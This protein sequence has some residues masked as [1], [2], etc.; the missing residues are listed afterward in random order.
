MTARSMPTRSVPSANMSPSPPKG[1][2]H[3]RQVT[4][5]PIGDSSQ[6]S[7]LSFWPVAPCD[8]GRAAGREGAIM[9]QRTSWAHRLA[10]LPIPVLALAIVTLWVADVQVVWPMRPLNFV[11]HY[12]AA[13]VG[14]VFIVIPAA[15]SFAGHRT[16]ER[17][18]ARLRRADDAD[19]GRHHAL[20]RKLWTWASPST[21]R[22][23]CC[24]PC[25]ISP[26]WPSPPAARSA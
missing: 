15:R 4:D 8:D 19:R 16:T 9:K 20:D 13:I 17:P 23:P 6:K 10:I 5:A 11:I 14:L 22:R 7:L 18:D 12:A 21:T 24:R 3:S 25:A 2:N 26:A 1:A